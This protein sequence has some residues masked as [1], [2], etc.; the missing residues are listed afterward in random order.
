MRWA[1]RGHTL[2]EHHHGCC[3]W[4]EEQV[5]L[6]DEI[7]CRCH[8]SH[9]SGLSTRR[10]MRPDAKAIMQAAPSGWSCQMLG[11]HLAFFKGLQK[12]GSSLLLPRIRQLH[13]AAACYWRIIANHHASPAATSTQQE[14][15]CPSMPCIQYNYTR[16]G[17]SVSTCT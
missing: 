13:N 11:Q 10:A 12:A 9:D 4:P 16:T 15:A 14:A 2:A 1:V 6:S 17:H 5:C 7:K 3:C 8:R